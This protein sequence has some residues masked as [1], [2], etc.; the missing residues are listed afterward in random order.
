MATETLPQGPQAFAGYDQSIF[1]EW[2]EGLTDLIQSRGEP[3]LMDK[4]TMPLVGGLMHALVL[5]STEL[6]ERERN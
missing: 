2:L 3:S 4:R 5:A 1:L 6:G